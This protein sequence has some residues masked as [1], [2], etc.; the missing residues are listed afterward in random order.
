MKE[1]EKINLFITFRGTIESII[2]DKRRDAKNNKLLN[3]FFAKVN[4]GLQ[5][6][7]DD[8]F[9]LNLIGGD[10]TFAVNR[11]RLEE[12]DLEILATPFDFVFFVNGE[13]STLHMVS[14]KNEF[15]FKKLRFAKSSSGKNNFGI[16]LK[17]R[18]LLVL[19]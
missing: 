15:G 8:Y 9:W 6:G 4:F 12:Y 7:E 2:E 13:N 18:K 5:F 17:V 16:L 19:D 14:K 3:D 11:G 1:S 10:G